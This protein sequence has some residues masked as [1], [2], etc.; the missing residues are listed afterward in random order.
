[1]R[2]ERDNMNILD[3]F[4][5][6]RILVIGD[7]MI[8]RYYL[9]QVKRIS[10]EAPVPVFLKGEERYVAGG[11]A[12]VAANLVYAGQDVV[13]ASVI[14]KDE[15]GDKLCDLMS[16][17]GCDCNSVVQSDKRCTS[18][19]TR[20]M[21]QNN[22]QLLRIDEEIN[23]N[24]SMVEEA[25]L[26][27]CISEMLDTVDIILL[28]DYK[29][30]VLTSTL[31]KH[32]IQRAKQKGCQVLVDVK[33]ADTEKYK[34]ATLLKPNRNELALLTGMSVRT[35]EEIL[36]AAKH[37]RMICNSEFVL[38]TL[39]SK[40]MVLV[41]EH[42]E[43]W[44][45]CVEHEVY[46]V[47]GAGD[48]VIAYLAAGFANG[49]DIL[50]ATQIANRAAGVKVTKLGTAPV[51]L[52]EVSNAYDLEKVLDIYGKTKKVVTTDELMDILKDKKDEKIVFTNGCFDV[53]HFGH[54]GYLRKAASY[55]DILIVG[56][57]SDASVKRLKGESR[58]IN[59]QFDR[60]EILSALEF[61][62]YVVIFEEDTP[63]DLIQEIRPDILVKGSDYKKED[64]VGADV[65]EKNG[66]RVELVS[67]LAEHS[68]TAIIQ[69]I[70]KGQ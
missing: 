40:G 5:R 48:T 21:A 18:I 8:D 11:A 6:K 26:L 66:G 56:L 33:D 32:V 46:D 1:M 45:A 65:V 13:L 42:Q 30:G 36:A 20:L 51:S 9:G 4:N 50:E 52:S 29:K 22:Q 41:G 69:K 27:K 59:S 2:R 37:L 7:L 61:V 35:N 16:E 12:N 55:G 58:P 10:P 47:S 64:V 14:G 68:T 23:E 43:E 25:E 54:V 63:L 60:A 28:S 15:Y 38:A 34:G 39:G 24:I 31:C 19:K 44:I 3:R 70:G 53:L 57:N 17:M 67:F 62:D 49:L